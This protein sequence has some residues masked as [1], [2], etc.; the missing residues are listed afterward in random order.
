MAIQK[1][2]YTQIPNQILDKMADFSDQEFKILLFLCRKTFGWHKK[3]DRISYSQISEGTGKCTNTIK[4]A[5]SRLSQEFGFII[6]TKYS[7]GYYYELN[8]SPDDIAPGDTLPGQ[9][10]SR[11]DTLSGQT[12][13]PGDTTK[14]SIKKKN[15]KKG[16]SQEIIIPNSLNSPDFIAAWEA[17]EKYRREIKKKLTPSTMAAQI[18][19]LLKYGSHGAVISIRQSIEKGW[20]GLFEPKAGRQSTGQNLRD[21]RSQAHDAIKRGEI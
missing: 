14:E 12:V 17:W 4:K 10:V 21:A 18:K 2:N 19:Q 1:S 3:R 13:S 5:I 6:Q 8:V 16:T 11:H 15:I 7:N 9:T 20:T